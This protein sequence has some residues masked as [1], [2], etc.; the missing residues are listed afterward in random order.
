MSL[1]I[2]KENGIQY[3]PVFLQ[4]LEDIPGG[5][6]IRTDRFPSTT[7]EIKAGAL[8]HA[9]TTSVGL[10]NLVK[11]AKLIHAVASDA[12]IM[13]IDPRNEFKAGEYIGGIATA[14]CPTILSIT[15]GTVSDAVLLEAK[16]TT[17]YASGYVLH[18][19]AAANATTRKYSANAIL[20]DSV[21]V[22]D[23]AGNL[24]ENIFAGAV[25]RGTVKESCLPYFAT[26][27]D[28]ASLTARIR[29]A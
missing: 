29:F 2:K 1:Q 28:K 12:T 23:D 7:K 17:G 9:D 26:D 10:Y 11:T 21:R 22:R 15:R 14:H 6:T 3:D 24:L 25:V 5:V 18:E 4:I 16:F 13:Y 27:V 19:A 20:R 8:L